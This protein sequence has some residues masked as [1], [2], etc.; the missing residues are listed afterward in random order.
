MGR[1]VELELLT[2]PEK[3]PHPVLLLVDEAGRNAI[4]SLYDHTTTVVGRGITLWIA[5]RSLSQLDAIYGKHRA[6]T[7]HNNCESQLYYR[8]A[9]Y[10]TAKYLEEC[11]GK[12]SEF[13][14]SQILHKGV[15]TSQGQVEQAVALMTAQAIKQMGDN[16]IIG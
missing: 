10:E 9:S 12:R 13:A 5:I 7:L 8:Q 6:D 14:H 4:P 3:W 11:L 15:E 2:H 1:E 16:E